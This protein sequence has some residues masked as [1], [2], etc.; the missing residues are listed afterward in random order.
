MHFF[1]LDES[2]DTGGNLTD[3]NQPIFVLAG[4]S[5]A[6]KKW[7]NTKESLDQ[8]LF[9]YFKGAVPIN[10]ELHATEL[11]SPNGEGPFNGHL[12]TDRLA[13]VRK[14]LA[15]LDDLGHYAHFFAIEKSKLA[16][17][18][19]EFE[20]PYD[21]K[22]PYL[23]AFDYL[24]TYINWHVKENLGRSARGMLVLD[25]KPE[26]HESIENIIHY[27]R[28]RVP[29]AQKVKWIVEFSYPVDSKKN[30]M[31]QLSDLICLC[32]RRFLEIELGYKPGTPDI[33]KNFYA[34][35]FH[36]LLKRIKS[37][38]LI[39]RKGKNLDKLTA[40]LDALQAKPSA[41]WR[42]KYTFLKR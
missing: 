34:D 10:F 1:Y 29:A 22:N 3:T 40:Y 17:I 33:V 41:H 32:V 15:L 9:D 39:E 23:V 25:E 36:A 26:H 7:N 14:L 42:K 38:S 20:I 37:K 24:I 5:V 35:C 2:G 6:D 16:A 21:A 19:C 8:I 27:R 31:I 18:S 4:L 12:I 13:L 30:P 11:L 28:F